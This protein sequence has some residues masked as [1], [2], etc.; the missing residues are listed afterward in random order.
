MGQRKQFD[1]ALKEQAVSR[2]L[3]GEATMADTAKD[4][5]VHYT[6]VRDWVKTYK[7]DGESAFP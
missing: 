2:I 7:L 6:T 4:L 1:K 3:A 5:N